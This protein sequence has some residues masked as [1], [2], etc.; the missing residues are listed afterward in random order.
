MA[1]SYMI[2]L[3]VITPLMMLL[4]GS[5]RRGLVSMFP[6]LIPVL[7]AV[8]VMGWTG[9]Y[10]DSTTMMVGAMI[11]GLAVDD[12]I[13][14]M[15]KFQ[16]YFDELGD[17]EAAIHETLRTTGV[18]LLVTTLVISAGLRHVRDGGHEQLARLRLRG[19]LRLRGGLRGGPAGSPGPALIA[20]P[21]H[22]VPATPAQAGSGPRHRTERFRSAGRGCER[23]RDGRLADQMP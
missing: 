8:G 18:A 19:F 2:A 13:H 11:I 9:T 7:A 21:P 17:F 5:L 23:L 3:L 14:F 4:L 12:T 16:R 6:N 1:R 10:L 20:A 22:E 15:H